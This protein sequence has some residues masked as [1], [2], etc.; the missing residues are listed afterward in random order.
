[1]EISQ[2]IRVA[3]RMTGFF[4]MRIFLLGGTPWEVWGFRLIS[5]W[6]GFLWIFGY[7][8]TRESAETVR[9]D[10]NFLAEGWV[11]FL[12]FARNFV[13]SKQIKVLFFSELALSR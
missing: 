7:Q 8:I 4:V 1:M 2:L 13:I 12:Y 3:N 5:G 11:E 9:F 6:R 10:G